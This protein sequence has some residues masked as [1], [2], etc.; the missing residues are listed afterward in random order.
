ME[1]LDLFT[2]VLSQNNVTQN[3]YIAVLI[4]FILCVV[5]IICYCV[6]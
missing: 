6:G 3:D 1:E 2:R 5:I 4:N